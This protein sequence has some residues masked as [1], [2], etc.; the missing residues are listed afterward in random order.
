MLNNGISIIIPVYNAEKYIRQCLESLM[1][2]KEDDEIILVNDGSTDKSRQICREYEKY[3][4]K[5]FNQNNSGVSAARNVGIQNASKSWLMFVDADDYLVKGWRKSVDEIINN[6][7]DADVMIFAKDVNEKKCTIKECIEAAVGYKND[8]GKTLG[9]PVS[10]IYRKSLIEQKKVCF[11]TELI[12]GEDMIFNAHVYSNCK[13]IITVKKSIYVY[14]KNMFSATNKFNSKIIKTEHVFHEELKK[15]LRESG[16]FTTVEQRTLYEKSLLNG[17]YA[18]M[19]RVGICKG[20]RN[21][22]YLEALLK[23]EE[24]K[25]ALENLYIYI[26]EIDKK[27]KVALYCILKSNVVLGILYIKILYMVKKL[28]YKYKNEGINLNI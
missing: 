1:E 9:M 11:S 13:K 25:N 15:I 12:N 5:L 3:N 24:Y 16:L 19:Y 4:I 26:N 27:K 23:E 2:I 28:I 20:F 21:K 18:V 8:L 14:Y 17:I 6:N 22:Q 10:K 7:K